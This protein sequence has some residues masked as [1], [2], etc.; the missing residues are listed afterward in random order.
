[1]AREDRPFEEKAMSMTI[2]VAGAFVWTCPGLVD[3]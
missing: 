2:I 1:M 3:S